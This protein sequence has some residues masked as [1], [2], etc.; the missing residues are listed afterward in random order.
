MH[1]PLFTNTICFQFVFHLTY[2]IV[3]VIN[4]EHVVCPV[5]FSIMRPALA[6]TA[7]HRMDT[8]K[9]LQKQLREIMLY[10]AM[11]NVEERFS[12]YRPCP[13]IRV[14]LDRIQLHAFLIKSSHDAKVGKFPSSDIC[15]R[16]FQLAT[17][18]ITWRNENV[19]SGNALFAVAHF[20]LSFTRSF[21][22]W[23]DNGD[24]CQSVIMVYPWSDIRNIPYPQNLGVYDRNCGDKFFLTTTV[25]REY[26]SYILHN[27]WNQTER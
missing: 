23:K 18:P 7:L 13:A 4:Y 6:T 10:T 26:G 24:I 14:R 5:Q 1:T 11:K 17:V 8:R 12:V 2:S 27:N 19:R 21:A 15:K 22:K 25:N 20:S 16:S 3:G 9:P